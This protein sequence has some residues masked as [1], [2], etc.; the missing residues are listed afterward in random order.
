MHEAPPFLDYN[1]CQEAHIS[2]DMRTQYPDLFGGERF[3]A[4]SLYF[5]GVGKL[6]KRKAARSNRAGIASK[7]P[8]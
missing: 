2:D 4:L 7:S 8:R 3:I 6:L 1:R 5:S